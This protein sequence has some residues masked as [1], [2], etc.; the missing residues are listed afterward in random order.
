MLVGQRQRE[1][2]AEGLERVLV[3]LL[4]LMGGHARLTRPAHAV[5]LLGLRQD[6]GRPALVRA[7]GGKGGVQ[8]AKI[9]AAALEGIDLG[10]GHMRDQGV[11]FRV[12]R[13]EVGEVVGAVLGAQRLVLAVRRRRKTAQQR[14]M[15]VAR[16]QAVPVRAP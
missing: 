14:M 1:A 9:M 6:D 8:L 2:I 5:A 15:G 7:R 4:R 11:E 16:E 10:V 12:L 13:K 3:E